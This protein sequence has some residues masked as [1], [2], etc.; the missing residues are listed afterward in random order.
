[1][2][3]VSKKYVDHTKKLMMHANACCTC[4]LKSTCD[5]LGYNNR[6]LNNP[7][8]DDFTNTSFQYSH[9]EQECVTKII[10]EHHVKN[11]SQFPPLAFCQFIICMGLLQPYFAIL[12]C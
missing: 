3:R 6:V 12:S 9:A 11:A 4:K 5:M 7:Y 10:V 2:H 1:M 8:S